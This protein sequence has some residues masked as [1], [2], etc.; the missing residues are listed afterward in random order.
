MLLQA[1]NFLSNSVGTIMGVGSA[2]RALAGAH[3]VG[4]G[5]TVGMSAYFIIDKYWLNKESAGDNEEEA[6]S[7]E[8]TA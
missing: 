1:Q 5:I 2:T 8:A 4:L 7:T 6:E 3:P